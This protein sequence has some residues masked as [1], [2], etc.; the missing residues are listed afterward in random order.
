MLEDFEIWKPVAGYE[1]LY[2]VSS[3]GRV[4]SQARIVAHKS[5]QALRKPK[6]LNQSITSRGYPCVGLRKNGKT[7]TYSV[8]RLVCEAFNG[9]P[10]EGDQCRH[11]D[12]ST[13][14]NKALNL[15]WG[16]WY[17]NFEDRKRHGTE[18][19]GVDVN[20]AKLKEQDVLKI[21]ASNESNRSLAKRYGVSP[22]HIG[23]IKKRKSWAWL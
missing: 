23:Y 22:T 19:K 20:T 14:N 12:G 10:G 21:R 1:G 7:K 15:A 13:S 3:H 17:E 18:V 16:S 9:P 8:H 6:I 2:L 5:G 11:L 4:F